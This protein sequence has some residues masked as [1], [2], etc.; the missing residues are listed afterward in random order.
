M[1]IVRNDINSYMYKRTMLYVQTI[2]NVRDINV[3]AKVRSMIK[4]R[5][6]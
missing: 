2:E 5:T 3:V 4:D 6:R 1:Y